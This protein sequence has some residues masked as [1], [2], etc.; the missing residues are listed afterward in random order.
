VVT[1][2]NP[3]V[4]FTWRELNKVFL[5]QA[6]LRTDVKKAVNAILSRWLYCTSLGNERDG[7]RA[8]RHAGVVRVV[9]KRGTRN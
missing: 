3:L 4:T 6:F 5:N 2:I 9:G 1:Y 8:V 7:I